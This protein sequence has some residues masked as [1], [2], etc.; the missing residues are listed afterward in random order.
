MRPWT[1]EAMKLFAD[2]HVEILRGGTRR[3]A[4]RRL[5]RRN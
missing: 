5:P 4:L 2:A 1:D 3:P